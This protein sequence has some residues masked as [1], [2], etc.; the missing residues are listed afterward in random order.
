MHAAFDLYLHDT[1]FVI[2][3][4]HGILSFALLCAVFAALYYFGGRFLGPHLS[5]GLSLA[6]F[7][8][9]I[10]A[11]VAVW[12]AEFALVHTVQARQDPN[13]SWSLLAGSVAAALA[14]LLGGL[15]FLIN[16]AWAITR[17]LRTPSQLK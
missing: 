4:G 10:F 6:H 11:L 2:S 14:F 12:A 17:K 8:F 13:Q 7:L 9:W 3:H 5:N 1:Y 15:L 16:F